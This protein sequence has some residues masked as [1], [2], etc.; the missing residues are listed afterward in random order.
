MQLLNN[1]APGTVRCAFSSAPLTTIKRLLAWGSS[2]PDG[3]RIVVCEVDLTKPVFEIVHDLVS[4]LAQAALAV[5]PDWYDRPDLFSPCNESTW[6][7]NLDQFASSRAAN[8]QRFVLR[9]WVQRAIPM[10][11]AGQPPVL[12][13][14]SSA[15]QIQQLAFAVADRDVALVVRVVAPESPEPAALLGLARNLEWLSQQVAARIVAVVSSS[16]YK[17]TELDCISW[18]CQ[19]VDETEPTRSDVPCDDEPVLMVCPIRGRPHPN[20]PGEQ[21]MA[22]RLRRDPQLGPLFE[23]N[24]PVTTVRNSRYQVDLVW[25]SGKIAVEIDGY[26]Y[27]SSRVEFE[28]DRH[29]DYEL[30]LT[31]YIVLRLTHDSVM[32][33]VELAIDKIRD[34]VKFRIEHPIS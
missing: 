2:R 25:F 11:R 1:V 16:W 18:E 32:N 14:F 17:R 9:S 27:H 3:D 31:G 26:G 12:K 15:I 22:S 20:S 30:Q 4:S 6:Q 34:F 7:S 13:E 29:R 10:C 21:L 5:W 24:M 23:Y 8:V 33:D 28:S 19:I